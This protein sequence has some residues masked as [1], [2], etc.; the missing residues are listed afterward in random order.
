MEILWPLAIAGMGLLAFACSASMGAMGSSGSE[1]TKNPLVVVDTSMGK[2]KAELCPE[3]SPGTVANFLKYVESGFFDGLVFHRVIPQFMI[4]GGGM[5]AAMKEK[6]SSSPIKNEAKTD[7][8][9]MRGTLA[10]ARTNDL[11]SAT[12]QFFVNLVDNSFLDHK[13]ES[14]RGFGYCVFGKVVEGMDVV[15]SM[16]RSKTTTKGPYADVPVTP[17]VINSI[18]LAD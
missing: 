12:S 18:R 15:D 1:G 17:V 16:A 11:H 3:K 8:R 13:D 5:D 6:R 9:N 10:M 4:Q 7:V 2:F 14:V